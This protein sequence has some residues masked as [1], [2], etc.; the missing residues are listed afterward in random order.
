M[1]RRE[2]RMTLVFSQ[3]TARRWEPTAE[4]E[5]ARFGAAAAW[6]MVGCGCG[7]CGGVVGGSKGGDEEK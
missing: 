5:R 4:E 6:S 7:G 1:D 3:C 2:A